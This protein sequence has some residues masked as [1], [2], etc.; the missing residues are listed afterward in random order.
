MAEIGQKGQEV[1]ISAK[2]RHH[3]KA[4]IKEIEQH[5]GRGTELVSVYVPAGYDLNKISSHIAQ[6]QGTASNIKSKQT[7]DNVVNALERMIQ[8]LKLFKQTP[9]NGLVAFAGNVA[10]RDGQQDYQVWSMEPP[11]PLNTRIYRCDKEFVLDPLRDMVQDKE[12][13]GMVVMDRR[14]ATLALLKGKTIVPLMKTHSEVP[15]K[16]RAGGQSAPRFARL[17]EGATKDHYKKVADYMKEQFLFLEG[18]KGIIIGGPSTTTNDFLNHEY[19]TGDV[20]KKIIGVK[21]LSY[22]DDFGLQELLEKS[23]DLLASE[24]V[25][26]EKELIQKLLT[27]L[28][29][30]PEMV[31]YGMEATKHALDLGA[32]D[33]L[34]LSESLEDDVIEGFEKRA[35]ELGTNIEIVSLDTREG[36][37]LRDLGKIAAFLR[38]P[39]HT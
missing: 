15:G 16:M 7:R 6:E 3:I 30:R 4:F 39:I 26:K 38:F 32:V 5:R 21:D 20:Q 9:P 18:L 10:E 25:A 23:Q 24:E 12:V 35:A 37:Q 29:K 28:A 11:L 31:S 22:T 36:V 8:H 19:I 17:R 14:D 13:Y 1:R 2:D 27:A 34:M 33:T